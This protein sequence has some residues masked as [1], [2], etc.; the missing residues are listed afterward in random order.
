MSFRLE[1]HDTR[2]EHTQVWGFMAYRTDGRS[3]PKGWIT[4][5]NAYCR[6]DNGYET[7]A[8]IEFGIQ[9]PTGDSSDHLHYTIPCVNFEQAQL[10]VAQQ[11]SAVEYLMDEWDE[12]KV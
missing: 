10:M 9:S 6:K 12:T 2:T 11:H 1:M 8:W 7:S 3:M 4:S 5:Y